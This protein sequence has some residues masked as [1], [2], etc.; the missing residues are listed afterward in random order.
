[1]D[2]QTSVEMVDVVLFNLVPVPEPGSALLLMGLALIGVRR[3]R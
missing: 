1:V 2:F 3:S